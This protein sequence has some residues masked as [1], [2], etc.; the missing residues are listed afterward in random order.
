MQ[1]A[2]AL[3]L[4]QLVEAHPCRAVRE[5]LLR[6]DR[7]SDAGRIHLQLGVE[8][9]LIAVEGAE[10]DLRVGH[11]ALEEGDQGRV[12]ADQHAAG[13]QV[14][15]QI[16]GRIG[17]AHL[18]DHVK[19]F[20]ARNREVAHILEEDD[21]RV[22][23]PDMRAVQLQRQ[24]VRDH[25]QLLVHD[26][27][28]VVAEVALRLRANLLQDR[29]G[30]MFGATSVSAVMDSLSRHATCSGCWMP[31]SAMLFARFCTMSQYPWLLNVRKKGFMDFFFLAFF[32]SL[33]YNFFLEKKKII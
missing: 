27:L 8:E 10:H 24:G 16:R 18:E 6:E 20:Q 3:L 19:I 4:H 30:S 17:A 23:E 31:D 28:V 13:A 14:K 32:F 7:V 29:K 25:L 1:H 2:Q 15:H 21:V 12:V 22:H 9:V 11:A 5:L 33:F 26:P